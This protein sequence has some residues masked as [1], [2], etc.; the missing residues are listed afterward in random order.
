MYF[1]KFDETDGI[2]LRL[3]ELSKTAHEK[4]ERYTLENP[5]EH[6]LTAI[7]L[8]RYRLEIK[9]HLRKE[10]KEIDGLV[11]KVIK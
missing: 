9:K 5:P 4:A 2:H 6:E 11:K 1:P 8:G 7:R 10:M 3:A